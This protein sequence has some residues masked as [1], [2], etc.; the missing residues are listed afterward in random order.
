MEYFSV[1]P[2]VRVVLFLRTLSMRLGDR[3]GRS[4][5]LLIR[6]FG[7][8]CTVSKPFLLFGLVHFAHVQFRV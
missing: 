2:R 5:A 3:N 1:P 6:L 8:V 4:R 7:A